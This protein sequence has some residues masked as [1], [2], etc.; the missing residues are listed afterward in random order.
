MMFLS[1]MIAL[2]L[3]QLIQVPAQRPG[4]AV[5]FSW[6]EWVSAR[7]DSAV[8]RIAVSLITP[9][10]LLYWILG[11]IDDWLFGLFSLL[12]TAAVLLW[13]L[14]REDYHTDLERYSAQCEAGNAEGAWLALQSLWTPLAGGEDANNALEARVQSEQRLLYCGYQRWFAPLFYFL[15][16]GPVAAAAYRFVYLF[17]ARKEQSGYRDLL[18]W[19]DWVPARLLA[20]SFAVTG[21]F[22][23]VVRG[24]LPRSDSN[25]PTLLRV[26]AAASAAGKLGGE[27]IRDLLYRTSGLWLI[28]AS[29]LIIA[30]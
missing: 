16:L 11:A 12:G 3:H 6:E 13:S 17:A 20:L 29:L 7:L 14:G 27:G 1:M 24:A 22:V 15:L 23:A 4:D 5:L 2:S 19:L 28:A 9:L 8:L 25:A 21:D 30:L 26:A 18:G 10:L